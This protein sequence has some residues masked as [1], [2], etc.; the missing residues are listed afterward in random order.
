MGAQNSLDYSHA[1]AL[2][3]LALVYMLR[4]G[5]M[6]PV[7]TIMKTVS[8]PMILGPLTCGSFG[9]NGPGWNERSHAAV[10]AAPPAPLTNS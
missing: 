7:K 9:Y 2:G 1:A 10:R 5:I 8:G 6:K 3:T 4:T